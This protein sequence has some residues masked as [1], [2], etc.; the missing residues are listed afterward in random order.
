MKEVECKEGQVVETALYLCEHDFPMR[1]V[2]GRV[3]PK[4]VL[5]FCVT[6]LF[7]DDRQNSRTPRTAKALPTTLGVKAAARE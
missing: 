4:S 1:Q 6:L 7:V 2:V 5:C 3:F